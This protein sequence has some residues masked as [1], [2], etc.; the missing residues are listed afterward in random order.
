MFIF[1][2]L[3]PTPAGQKTDDKGQATFGHLTV[4]AARYKYTAY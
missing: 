3:T 2:Q 4:N 1:G